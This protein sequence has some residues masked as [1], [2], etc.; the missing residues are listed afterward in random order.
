[1]ALYESPEQTIVSGGSLTLA[2]GLGAAPKFVQCFLKCVV[3]EHGYAVGDV[4]AVGSV[5]NNG[6]TPTGAAIVPSAS[7]IFIRFG[8]PA[9]TWVYAMPN[10]STGAMG[11]VN[12]TSFRLIVRAGL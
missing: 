5:M 12:N 11:A 2:H 7:N 9:A 6:W 10:K 8:N 4:V 1:M 3:A